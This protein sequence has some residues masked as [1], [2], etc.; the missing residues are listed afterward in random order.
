MTLISKAMHDIEWVDSSDYG[1]GDEI[2]AIEAV[3]GDTSKA[4]R[5]EVLNA[6]AEKLIKK[7]T[8]LTTIN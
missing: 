1:P 6:D 8:D 7:L 2:E 4:R 5:I 3:F